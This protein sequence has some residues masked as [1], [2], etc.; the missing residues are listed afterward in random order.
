LIVSSVVGYKQR[1]QDFKEKVFFDVYHN[2]LAVYEDVVSALKEM[3]NPDTK[4]FSKLNEIEIYEKILTNAHLVDSLVT[5][6]TLF[7]SPAAAIPIEAL[8]ISLLR[9]MQPSLE[10]LFKS[11]DEQAVIL[12]VTEMVLG[13]HKRIVDIIRRETGAPLVD[14]VIADV[15]KDFGGKKTKNNGKQKP[16]NVANEDIRS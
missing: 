2:R 9:L 1:K 4:E 11:R 5:R 12:E 14:D 7:G 3:S 13:T 10:A 15:F 6:V 8:R 16:H